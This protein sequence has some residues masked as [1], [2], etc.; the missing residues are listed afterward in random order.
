MV[1]PH[2]QRSAADDLGE[3]Y[4]IAPRRACRVLGRSRSTL[5]SRG[6]PRADEPALTRAIQQWARRHPRSGDRLIPARRARQG[7]EV[8]RKRVHRL[9]L[10]LGLNRP[11]RRRT[12]RKLGPKPGVSAY[13]CVPQPARF[14]NDIG[15]GDFLHDR[16]ADGRP[17]QW[18]TAVDED[19]R[20]CWV[21]DAAGSLTGADV[22]RIM[23][24]VIG[25]RGAPTRIRSD[26]GSEFICAALV[27]W[28]PGKGAQSIPVAPGS[29]WENGS[30]ESFHNR[31]RD[32]FFER[33]EFESVSDAREKGRWY[34]REYNT[35]QPHSSLGYATPK[36]FSAACDAKENNKKTSK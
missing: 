35:V 5:R 31:A 30:I 9:G 25:H 19:T 18:L 16:T 1:S 26:N 27:D 13:S 34:R 14:Q 11:V 10:E 21:L 24:R 32:E 20:E 2:Q 33:E 8:N 7:W 29:P 4:G 28:L 17:L 36:E 22:R 23:A 15:T 3:R 6:S 12:P